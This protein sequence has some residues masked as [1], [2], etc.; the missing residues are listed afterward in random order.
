MAMTATAEKLKHEL[1]GLS[2]DDRAGL[3]RFLLQ[4]LPL[5]PQ[6]STEQFD[7]ELETRAGEIRAGKV[8]GEPVEKV[9]TELRE[10]F[11]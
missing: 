1:A 7:T 4:S 3:A 8:V 9:I 10:K 6:P 11:S 5:P 2:L